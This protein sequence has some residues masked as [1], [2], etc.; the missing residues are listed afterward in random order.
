[1]KYKTEIKGV[2]F[3]Y[4]DALLLKNKEGEKEIKG[5]LYRKTTRQEGYLWQNG[6]RDKDLEFSL[7]AD[8][9][10]IEVGDVVKYKEK[11]F[12]IMGVLPLCIREID[13]G[14]T[15]KAILIKT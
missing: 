4:A 8:D 15:A 5:F 1:M 12:Y 13:A 2:L 3:R 11:E 9:T 14:V 10:S 6:V 7:V